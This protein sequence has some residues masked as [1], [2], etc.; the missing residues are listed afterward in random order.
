MPPPFNICDFLDAHAR[1]P[2]T[3]EDDIFGQKETFFALRLFTQTTSGR[4]QGNKLILEASQLDAKMSIA[5]LAVCL[6]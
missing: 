4:E 1:V 2:T 5:L 3:V 6:C